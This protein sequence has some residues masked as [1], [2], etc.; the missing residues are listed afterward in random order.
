VNRSPTG[1]TSTGRPGQASRSPAT[2]GHVRRL[3]RNLIDNALRYAVSRVVITATA[4]GGLA[5]IEIDDDGPGIPAAD[6]SR[7][8]G[9]RFSR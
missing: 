8:F 2:G 3:F 4:D 7:V 9:G 5:R 1:R 6:R